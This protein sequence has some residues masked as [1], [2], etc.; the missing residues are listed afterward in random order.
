M[1]KDALVGININNLCDFAQNHLMLGCDT[2][3][4]ECATASK[5]E[6]RDMLERY[7]RFIKSGAYYC[8][9]SITFIQ[10][11][12]RNCLPYPWFLPDFKATNEIRT[13]EKPVE[14]LLDS[15]TY[16]ETSQPRYKVAKA[17]LDVSNKLKN[18]IDM[19]DPYVGEKIKQL[20]SN[21]F[22]RLRELFER[23]D[24]QDLRQM[25]VDS[26][27]GEWIKDK[28][29]FG[30][31]P[32]WMSWQR[33]RLTDAIVRNYYY[34]RLTGAMPKDKAERAEHD[35]QDMEYVL[36]LSRADAI[37][38]RDKKL[39][40]PL[41]RAAFPEKNVFSNLGEVPKDYACNWT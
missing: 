18:R 11:E 32:E 23:I 36:L 37:L 9:C 15:T 39:V 28:T 38:T 12:S 30:L 6:P 25:C 21:K 1:D 19:E 22:E 13:G 5:Q 10:S 31:S 41:A 26:V 20:P 29:K 16:G 40:E 33:I 7:K 35:Y 17:F 27:R 8:S 34:L 2:L 24:T 14:H 3:L 4:Y